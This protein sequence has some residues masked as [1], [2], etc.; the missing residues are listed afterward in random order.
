MN[1][2]SLALLKPCEVGR[3]QEISG[4]RSAKKRLYELGLNTGTQV[5]MVKNDLGPVILNVSGFKLA[6]GRGLANK[7]I[8]EK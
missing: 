8:V 5:K 6:L 2:V 7:I 1:N 3:I 4:G